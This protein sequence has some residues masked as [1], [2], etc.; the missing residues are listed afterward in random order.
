MLLR[1]GGLVL[2]RP[3]GCGAGVRAGDSV[4]EPSA[5]AYGIFVACKGASALASPVVRGA[6]E[7]GTAAVAPPGARFMAILCG[8]GFSG[9]MDCGFAA[10]GESPGDRAGAVTLCPSPKSSNEG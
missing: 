3:A 6:A 9:W 7:G 1:A 5:Q 4:H 2:V 10:T 8:M